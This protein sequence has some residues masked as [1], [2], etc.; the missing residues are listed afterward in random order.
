MV[1]CH[2]LPLEEPG[3]LGPEMKPDLWRMMGKKEVRKAVVMTEV[4]VT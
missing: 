2:I 3:R 4:A 1:N